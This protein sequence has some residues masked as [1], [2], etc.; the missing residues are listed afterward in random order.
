MSSFAIRFLA[1]VQ[2]SAGIA[3]RLAPV[4]GFNNANGEIVMTFRA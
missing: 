1:G 2:A 4:I 3:L